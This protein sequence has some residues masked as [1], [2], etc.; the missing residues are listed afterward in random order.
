MEDAAA[1]VINDIKSSWL[2][3]ILNT[4]TETEDGGISKLELFCLLP[5]KVTASLLLSDRFTPV[6]FTPFTVLIPAAIINELT[7][8]IPE[9]FKN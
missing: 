4:I 9:D 8:N 7:L 1:T 3:A 2:K 6:T 5:T